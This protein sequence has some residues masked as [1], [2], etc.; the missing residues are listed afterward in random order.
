MNIVG[1][2][3]SWLTGLISMLSKGLSTV[4]SS[5]KSWKHQFIITQP[6]LWSNSHLYITTGKTI[7][8]TTWT[9]VGKVTSL[10]FNMLLRFVIAFLPRSNCLLILWLKSLS[11]LTLEPKET[12][13]ITFSSSLFHE[14]LLRSFNRPEP[15]GPQLTIR[16]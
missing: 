14:V 16:K 1:W 8:L 3:P 7:A 5:T 9:F 11:A 12:K 10:L 2:F 13:S 6:S 15:G 4:F